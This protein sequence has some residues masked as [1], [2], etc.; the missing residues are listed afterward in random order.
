MSHDLLVALCLV[1][2]IEGIFPFLSPSGWRKTLGAALG[3]NDQSLRL[4]GLFSMLL[5]TLL[6]YLVN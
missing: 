4:I 3:M 5:G 6:L 2:V 1:L